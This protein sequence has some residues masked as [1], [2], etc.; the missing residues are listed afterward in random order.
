[1]RN[2]WLD[3]PLGDYEAHMALPAIGQSQLIADQLDI[4]VRT[5]APSSVAILGCAGG[6]GFERLI[7]TSVSRVVG[8]DINPHFIEEARQRDEGRVPGLKLLVADIQTSAWLFEP[9]DFI[10]AAL[11]FE[12]VDVAR[13]MSVLRRHCTPNGILAVLSQVPHMALPEVSPSPYTRLRLLAPGMHL[14]SHEE[15]QRHAMQMGFTPKDSR[16]ILSPG[17]KQFI[18]ET[19]RLCLKTPVGRGAV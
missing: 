6:N 3:V 17:G 10:Y 2:P 19:F 7:D 11:V 14:L 16:K 12:Y 5:Y 4:L 15:L 1:M 18:V 13:T 9:V 8:I